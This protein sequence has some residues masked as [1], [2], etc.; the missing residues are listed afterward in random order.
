ML[1]VPQFSDLAFVQ[2]VL[3]A[4]E[5]C[6][7]VVSLD[8]KLTFMSEGGM[9]VMEVSDFNAI[10]GCPWP[11]FWKGEGN[12]QAREAVA[13]A[14]AGKSSRFVG[15]AD[16]MR[17]TSKW[18]DVQVSPI[19]DPAGKPKAILSVSRDITDLKV[20]EQQAARAAKRRR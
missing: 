15:R 6:I 18:W 9:R 14:A 17:G 10:A 12:Q 1:D 2:S 11:D 7:K 3:A 19:F 5:D 13:K 8:G 4:S 16:T 20:A